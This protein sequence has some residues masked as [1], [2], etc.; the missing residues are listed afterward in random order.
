[1]IILLRS[2]KETIVHFVQDP[3]RTDNFKKYS[4]E[5]NPKITILEILVYK[6]QPEINTCKQ[7]LNTIYDE[8]SEGMKT[9]NRCDWY[10]FEKKTLFKPA[11]T[12]CL[13]KYS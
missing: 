4:K 2:V 12:P 10:Q 1:M 13:T 8:I 3:F 11:K 5:A 6:I 9:R 7:E